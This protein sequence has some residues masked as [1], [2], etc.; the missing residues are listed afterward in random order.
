MP[1]SHLLFVWKVS[2]YEVEEREGPGPEAG[3]EVEED[4]TT[5]TVVKVGPSPFPGDRRTCAYVMP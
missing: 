5:M 2:G 1:E 4:G 3:A